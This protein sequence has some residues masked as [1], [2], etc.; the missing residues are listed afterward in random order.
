[1]FGSNGHGQ[2]K[3]AY[4]QTMPSIHSLLPP[5][6]PSIMSLFSNSSSMESYYGVGGNNSAIASSNSTNS[7]NTTSTSNN[8]GATT[9]NNNASSISS[10]LS[11]DYNIIT[12]KLFSTIL[13]NYNKSYNNNSSQHH[14]INN[15]IQNDEIQYDSDHLYNV[16]PSQ[17]QQIQQEQEQE[18]QQQQQL[19]QQQLQQQQ[20]RIQQQQQLQQS[21]QIIKNPQ[22]TD[23]AELNSR[24]NQQ[25]QNQINNETFNLKNRAA[26]T[27]TSCFVSP[28]I[29]TTTISDDFLDS[30]EFSSNGSQIEE[31]NMNQ[32][33]LFNLF[34]YICTLVLFNS[35]I[36]SSDK[37]KAKLCIG[38]CFT[39]F[40][41]IPSWI[42]FFWLSGLNK[43]AIMA[44]IALP[45]SFSSLFILKK[46]GSTHFPGH[47]LCFTLCFAL[48]INAYYTG[49][50]QSTIRLL[51]SI[52]PIISA[53]VIGRK[54]SVQ[55]SLIV[56]S[57]F[58]F[59]FLAN[60]SGCEYIEGIPTITIRSH[61]N[62]I[63]DVT[64]VLITMAFTLCYQYFIDEAHK[65]TKIKNAQLTIAKD[66]AIEAYQA[67]QE[68]LA[69][70]SHE[71]RT[72]LNGLIGMATLL[73]D[74]Y[75][76]PQEERQ[77]AK[78]VKSCGDIL[79]R[80]VND[81][82]DLSKLE[83]NQM[84]LENI[85]FR[86]RDLTQQIIQVLSGQAQERGL[87]LFFELSNKIP[88]VL[89]GDS[90]R[91]LQVLMNL[92][93]NALKFTQSGFVKIMIDL[94]EDEAG[95]VS[96][97]PGVYNICF[98]VKDSGIGV[99]PSSY[100]KIFEAFVQADPSDSRRY[101]GSG[102]GLYLCAKLVKLMNGEIGVYNNQDSAGSTFWFILPL[103]VGDE[104]TVNS[105]SRGVDVKYAPD[106][107]KVLIA[108]DNIVNQ[109]VAVKFLEK[110]G[111]RAD[112]ATNGNQVLDILEKQHYDLI[113]MDFQMPGLDGL[114]CSK[115]IRQLE[116][117]GKWNHF[118]S[119]YICGL[120]AN[121]MSTD[122]KRCFDHG[123]NHFISKPF[124]LEQLKNAI[125]LAIE[126]KERYHYP[127]RY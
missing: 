67:R 41:F 89:T 96:Q 113:F 14:H 45:M 102:L 95:K 42:I 64:I 61:M 46:T 35:N 18:Q 57:I 87:K 50:H 79:L 83:A 108:E 70:M 21:Q 5:K 2:Y 53:L 103:E 17:H 40:S 24:F 32:N 26:K 119:I 65:E 104:S 37:Y 122:K 62:F 49:G 91:I 55:W 118:S 36:K 100:Q 15:I 94:I 7:S 112:V 73:C 38:F 82:L 12:N 48:T 86:I 74:S 92:T 69:M 33:A 31:D 93:G 11:R 54:A 80:L 13:P 72:P 75:Q 39:I 90:G 71:I 121:T 99:P 59:F 16:D 68:F 127:Y 56:L 63:I 109:K 110:I 6:P 47:I 78:A 34:N 8:I 101:G 29:T 123:M 77:M 44:I 51:M 66:A 117:E 58:L 85:P 30:D 120:T 124:Q 114:R 76:L 107:V 97:K 106:R 105:I 111:I 4:S 10:T 98:M 43:P 81:I 60:L 25:Q 9:C 88:S 28:K 23:E 27:P 19:Q 3:S 1:M 52:V 116:N 126:Y 22:Y 20:N 115:A 84:G 125:D